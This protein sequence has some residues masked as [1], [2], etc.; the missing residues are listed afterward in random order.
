MKSQALIFTES[1]FERWWYLCHC[2]SQGDAGSGLS[3][4]MGG[5]L[6]T[7][8]SNLKPQSPHSCL[9]G[10]GRG[11]VQ[12][13]AG[14]CFPPEAEGAAGGGGSREEVFFPLSFL[15]LLFS[16]LLS[17][18]NCGAEFWAVL[19]RHLVV[20]KI[21][22]PMLLNHTMTLFTRSPLSRQLTRE[23]GVQLHSETTTS[24]A[25]TRGASRRS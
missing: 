5:H 11:S 16:S 22:P 24:Q 25:Q 14:P 20:V 13:T 2:R 7:S 17:L 10:A 1:S 15:F 4:V 9:D 12:R 3:M 18:Q 19:K 21:V 23:C 6:A 8:W